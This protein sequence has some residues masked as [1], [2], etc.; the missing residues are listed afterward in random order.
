MSNLTSPPIQ[1]RTPLARIAESQ[2]HGV[3]G[4]QL[5]QASIVTTQVFNAEVGTPLDLRTVEFTVLAL[6]HANPGVTARQL[7]RGL[8][9]TPPNIA[10]WLDRL[11]SRGLVERS[12]SETDAR[13]QHLR[14]T[15][16]GAALA[17][18]ATRRLVDGENAALAAL[19]VAER[20]M[21]VELLHKAAMMRKR[22]PAS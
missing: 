15:T 17:R 9:L 14:A 6:V 8:A 19:S 4:Y 2:L 1:D 16:K 5:A 12:R 18:Q 21:L 20:A 3:V 7:A 22:S 13:V 10:V 11:A